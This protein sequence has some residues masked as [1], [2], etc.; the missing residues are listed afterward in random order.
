[1]NDPLLFMVWEGSI[2]L[3]YVNQNKIHEIYFFL[4]TQQMDMI[5]S[6]HCFLQ[7]HDPWKII[8]S[9]NTSCQILVELANGIVKKLIILYE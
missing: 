5:S 9:L 3:W 8:I 6:S 7:L 2:F 1:M 4:N